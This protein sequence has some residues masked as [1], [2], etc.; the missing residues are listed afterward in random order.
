MY[1]LKFILFILSERSDQRSGPTAIYR[2]WLIIWLDGQA[3]EETHWNIDN[4]E[5][6]KQLLHS[7]ICKDTECVLCKHLRRIFRGVEF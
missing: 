4:E 6:W 7:F 2:Q 5:T 3:L 1:P